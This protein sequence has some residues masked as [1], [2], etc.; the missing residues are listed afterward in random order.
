MVKPGDYGDGGGLYLQ[1]T[2]GKRQGVMKSWIFRYGCRKKTQNSDLGSLNTVSL[3]D[4][5]EKAMYTAICLTSCI[6]QEVSFL[7][8]LFKEI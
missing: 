2:L 7:R 4:A 1:V 5:R 8:K 3:G 6:L